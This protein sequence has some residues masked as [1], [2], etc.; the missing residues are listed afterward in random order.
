MVVGAGAT[1]MWPIGGDGR[2]SEEKRER[3]GFHYKLT[4][5]VGVPTKATVNFACGA[6]GRNCDELLELVNRISRDFSDRYLGRGRKI[7]PVRFRLG[8]KG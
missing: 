4:V 2:S 3:E 6:I 1:P 5:R 8:Q 7:R